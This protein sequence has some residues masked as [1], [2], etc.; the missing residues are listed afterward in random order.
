M[1]SLIV[2]AVELA[3]LCCLPPLSGLA[4]EAEAQTDMSSTPEDFKELGELMVGR[5]MMDVTLIADWPGLSKKQ[6]EKVNGYM[7]ANWIV[8]QKGLEQVE[9]IGETS[10]KMLFVWDPG[11]KRI[12]RLGVGSAGDVGE[13][14]FWKDGSKWAWKHHATLLDLKQAKA[15]WGFLA[16]GKKV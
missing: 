14:V 13:T 16:F 9:H 3:V 7:S 6:G 12:R 4:A 1:K 8:D 15:R 5:W 10:T 2:Y 11:S